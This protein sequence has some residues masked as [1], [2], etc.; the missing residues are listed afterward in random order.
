MQK[1]VLLIL[2][3]GITATAHAQFNITGKLKD[4]SGKPVTVATISLL[5][6]SD[7]SW[8]RSEY[9]GDSGSFTFKGIAAGQYMIDIYAAGYKTI[10]Q[11]LTITGNITNLDILVQKNSTTLNEVTVTDKKQFIEQGLGKTIINVASSITAAGNSV[12]DLLRKSP[13]ITVDMNGNI[14]MQGKQGILVLID[15]KE[16]YLTGQQLADYLRSLSGSEVAQLE[17]ITQPSARYD[18]EG[19]AG[20]INIKLK[21]NKKQGWNG[22]ASA[23]YKQGVY[24]GTINSISLEHTKNKLHL[25]AS[26]RFLHMTGFQ[27]EHSWRNIKDEQTGLVT[28]H[29]TEDAWLTE[30]FEDHS[31]KFGAEYKPSDKTTFDASINGI[32][33]TNSEYDHLTTNLTDVNNIYTLNDAVTNRGFLRHNIIAN[34]GYHHDFNKDHNIAIVADYLKRDENNFDDAVNSQYNAQLQPIPGGDVFKD[35]RLGIIDAYTLRADYTG[36]LKNKIKVEAGVKSSYVTIRDNADFSVLQNNV[37]I[38]DTIRT[39]DFNYYENINAAYITASRNFGKKWETQLGLRCENTS[40]TGRQAIGNT[41]FHNNNTAVFPTFFAA[42]TANDKNRFELNYGRRISRPAYTWLNPFIRYYS[43]YNYEVGNPSL[44]PEYANNIELK[45]TYNNKFTTTCSYSHTNGLTSDAYYVTGNAIYKL[46]QNVAESNEM[47]IGITYNTTIRKWWSLSAS[48]SCNHVTFFGDINGRSLYASG[49]R[50]YF[51]M[52]NQFSFIKGWAAEANLFCAGHNIE[53]FMTYEEPLQWLS[54]G[55]SKKLFRDTTV[56]K[57]SIDDP[58]NAYVYTPVLDS[59]NL[60]SRTERTWD[61]QHLT[62]NVTYSFGNNNYKQNKHNAT[63][64]QG[65]MGM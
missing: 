4:N 43:Q 44:Q 42:Y 2:L 53:R 49:F 45:H 41:S 28:D 56:I 46:V 39:N 57:L 18:A 15:N 17:L 62:L 29:F 3:L 10:K 25:S 36:Q 51:N 32:Y 40:T 54:L 12:L 59:Y 61:N 19:N 21:K 48:A 26:Y 8:V 20:I 60:S 9:T 27:K 58:F 63:E 38:P 5:N 11:Q 16:T 30:T 65:R 1:T 47:G 7:S 37:Y 35:L 13:G 14:T 55:F 50:S 31:L 24:P 64:E 33:H 52:N 34:C 22:V 6:A 23:S